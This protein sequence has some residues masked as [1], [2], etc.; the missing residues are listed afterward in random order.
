MITILTWKWE[1]EG[2]HRKKGIYFLSDHVNILYSMLKRHL[3]TP[4]RLA[5]VTDNPVGIGKDVLII[6]LWSDYASMGGCFRRLK[7]FSSEAEKFLHCKRFVSIDLDVVITG[8]ITPLLTRKDDFIIWGEDWRKFVYCGAMWM[9]D[10]GARPQVW[11]S[12]DCVKYSRNKKGHYPGGTDQRHINTVLYPGEKTWT[13]KD[14]VYNFATDIVRIEK[15][16][17]FRYPGRRKK[18]SGGDG[19]LP[20]GA[21]IVFFNGKYDPSQSS[22]REEYPWIKEHWR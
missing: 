6:P 17:I 11:D 22:L 2:L 19:R 3:H 16:K 1:C 10:V 15:L 9:M 4:F 7:V 18:K 20:K 14:G 12:F 13:Q 8:D 5:C 21:R